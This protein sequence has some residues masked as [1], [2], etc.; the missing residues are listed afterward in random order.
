[1]LIAELAVEAADGF[2]AADAAAVGF[3][4]ADAAAVGFVAADALESTE[5]LVDEF[6]TDAAFDADAASAVAACD[7]LAFVAEELLA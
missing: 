1:M 6:A 4:A 7:A 5:A 3:V 2:V